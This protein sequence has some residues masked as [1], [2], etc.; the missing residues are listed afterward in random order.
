MKVFLLLAGFVW[1]MAALASPTQPTFYSIVQLDSVTFVQTSHETQTACN[2]HLDELQALGA[3]TLGCHT[4]DQLGR[5]AGCIV[6]ERNVLSMQP[7]EVAFVYE[8][9]RG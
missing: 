5:T 3:H 6:T 4:S 9:T 1:N 8:C 2:A 7:V